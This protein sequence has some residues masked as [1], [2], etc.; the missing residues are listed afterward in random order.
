MKMMLMLSKYERRERRYTEKNKK[1]SV[2]LFSLLRLSCS[3]LLSNDLHFFT[4]IPILFQKVTLY[5]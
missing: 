3:A 1:E 5:I 2:S 4:P